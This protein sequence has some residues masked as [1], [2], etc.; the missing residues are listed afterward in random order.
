MERG[1]CG[2][3]RWKQGSH[4]ENAHWYVRETLYKIC[5]DIIISI[6]MYPGFEKQYGHRDEIVQF[7]EQATLLRGRDHPNIH[8]VLKVSVEDNYIPLVVYPIVEY[9]NMHQ[10]LTFC[11]VSPNESPLNVS[12]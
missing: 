7:V 11:R 12:S 5:I 1:Q 9:G 8:K 6:Y 2:P 3:N 10:F 4:D